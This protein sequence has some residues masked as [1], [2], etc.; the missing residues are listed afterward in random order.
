MKVKILKDWLEDKKDEDVIKVKFNRTK[1]LDIKDFFI[2]LPKI[3]SKEIMKSSL[4]LE[5]YSEHNPD[6]MRNGTIR[7]H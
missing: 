3:K 1:D 2:E 4:T 5:D 7:K 6:R